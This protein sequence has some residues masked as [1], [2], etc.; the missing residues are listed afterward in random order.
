[1]FVAARDAGGGQEGFARAR[2]WQ[3]QRVTRRSLIAPDCCWLAGHGFPSG[4][5]AEGTNFSGALIRWELSL[6]IDRS[7]IALG[8]HSS[9]SAN[10]LQ[11]NPLF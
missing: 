4:T 2:S 11:Q 7:S 5:F 10:H 9:T 8:L 3:S 6:T 1:M